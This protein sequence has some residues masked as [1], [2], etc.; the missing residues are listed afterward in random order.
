MM[1]KENLCPFSSKSYVLYESSLELPW[2]GG[3]NE[4]PQLILFYILNI[5][6]F[7]VQVSS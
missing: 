7:I 4:S 5:K 3:C 1:T 2:Q 6:K